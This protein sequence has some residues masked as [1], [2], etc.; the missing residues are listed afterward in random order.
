MGG[1][2]RNYDGLL[3]HLMDP[4]ARQAR[5]RAVEMLRDAA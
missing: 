5:R 4:V 3:E 1:Q 2:R